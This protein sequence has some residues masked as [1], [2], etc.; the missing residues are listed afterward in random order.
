MK[1][2]SNEAIYQHYTNT[3]IRSNQA[4]K[5]FTAQLRPVAPETAQCGAHHHGQLT[6]KQLSHTY[7][8]RPFSYKMHRWHG[9]TNVLIL[10]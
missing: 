6:Y 8:W 5:I 2:H 10:L 4:V 9:K 3:I 1:K 7:S